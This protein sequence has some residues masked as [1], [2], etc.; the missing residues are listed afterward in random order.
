V[1]GLPSLRVVLTGA[2]GTLDGLGAALA[3]AGLACE[4]RPLLGFG[5]P[6]SWQAMDEA[7]ARLHHY[8]AIAITSPRAAESLIERVRACGIDPASAP[9]IWSG[10]ASAELLRTVFPR[11]E[12]P[13]ADVVEPS[14]LAV[15]LAGAMLAAGVGSP[16]LFPCGEVHREEL[17]VRLRAAGRRVEPVIAYRAMLASPEAIS[18][19]MASGDILVVTSPRVAQHLA[20][21]A[22]DDARPSMV[23]I[24][25]TTADAAAAAGWSPDAVAMR[26]SVADV[27]GA[28][29]ALLP[30]LT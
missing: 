10:A 16:V 1:S 12:V 25:P 29:H 24:G 3:T 2:T 21:S 13:T 14:S 22:P 9:T 4:D 5:P 11:V 26:P 28:I 18:A 27:V 6:L 19:A 20:A 7:I 30:S 17:L 23:A 15:R 8:A